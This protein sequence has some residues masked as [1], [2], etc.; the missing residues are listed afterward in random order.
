MAIW[1]FLVTLTHLLLSLSV[2]SSSYCT[3][4]IV[5]PEK[6]VAPALYLNG[7]V[8]CSGIELVWGG[9]LRAL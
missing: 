1:E 8:H 4:A 6:Q 9:D 7:L 5:G 3:S 2:G